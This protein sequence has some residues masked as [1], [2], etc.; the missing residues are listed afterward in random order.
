MMPRVKFITDLKQIAAQEEN[1]IDGTFE[2]VE[3]P[4]E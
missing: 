3:A 4:A 2:T 1:V